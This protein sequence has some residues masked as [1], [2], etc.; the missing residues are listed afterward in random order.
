MRPQTPGEMI[1]HAK[2]MKLT[3]EEILRLLQLRPDHYAPLK[4]LLTK[5]KT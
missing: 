5:E 2:E 1:A 3:Q 4:V